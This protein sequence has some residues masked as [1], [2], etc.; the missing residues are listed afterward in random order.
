MTYAEQYEWAR[1]AQRLNMKFDEMMQADEFVT[2]FPDE[3]ARHDAIWDARAAQM[4]AQLVLV[5]TEDVGSEIAKIVAAGFKIKRTVPPSAIPIDELAAI[6]YG[7][8]DEQ[9]PVS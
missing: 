9:E 1:T 5:A 3:R 4:S 2:A 6:V 8:P 7:L